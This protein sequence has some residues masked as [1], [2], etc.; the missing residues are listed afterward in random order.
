MNEKDNNFIRYLCSEKKRF[1]KK[2]GWINYAKDKII[3]R[4]IIR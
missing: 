4:E 3:S 2:S 1:C